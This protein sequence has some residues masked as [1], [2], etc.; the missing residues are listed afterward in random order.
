[1]K[2]AHNWPSLSPYVDLN[3]AERTISAFDGNIIDQSMR[4]RFRQI[5]EADFMQ[6]ECPRRISPNLDS[7]M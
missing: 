7:A 4:S 1:V 3:A 5:P 2:M 6:L